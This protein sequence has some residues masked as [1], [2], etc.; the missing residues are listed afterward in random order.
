M[1]HDFFRV[2]NIW[3]SGVATPNMNPSGRCQITFQRIV[4]GQFFK[5]NITIHV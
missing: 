5:I 3:S 1:S 2:Q 4:F